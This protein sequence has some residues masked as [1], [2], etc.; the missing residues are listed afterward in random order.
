MSEHT[1]GTYTGGTCTCWNTVTLGCP[2]H[3]PQPNPVQHTPSTQ[4]WFDV[5]GS[6]EDH[7][8]LQ[9]PVV[10]HPRVA[11]RRESRMKT[12]LIWIGKWIRQAGGI[13]MPSYDV[14]YR[15]GEN[16]RA[17]DYDFALTEAFDDIEDTS[18]QGVVAYIAALKPGGG[19]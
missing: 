17:A 3:A 14:G 4:V 6:T 2:L 19:A 16:N 15:D 18:P 12:M 9:W 7:H 11:P 1:G 10:E 8:P 5:T 13:H